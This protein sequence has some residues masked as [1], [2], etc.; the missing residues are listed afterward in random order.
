[1][2]LARKEAS[3]PHLEKTKGSQQKVLSILHN[4][5]HDVPPCLSGE[6]A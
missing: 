2:P 3:G 4:S 6:R 1:M 5:G